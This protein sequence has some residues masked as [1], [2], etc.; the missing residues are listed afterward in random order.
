MKSKNLADL[1][2]SVGII[3]IVIGVIVA[4]VLLEKFGHSGMFSEGKISMMEV[5]VSLAVACYHLA[6][7]LICIGISKMIMINESAKHFQKDMVEIIKS[8]ISQLK[9]NS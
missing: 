6:I 5:A 1:I 9:T 8:L 4:F 3:I 7:G 2:F